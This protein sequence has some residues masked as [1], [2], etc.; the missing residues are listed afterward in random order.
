[1][2]TKPL[3]NRWQQA[4][5]ERCLTEKPVLFLVG[6]RQC[7]KTSLV[8]GLQGPNS[9][10]VYVSM[11]SSATLAAARSDPLGFVDSQPQRLFIIDE[12]SRAPELFPAIKQVVDSREGGSGQFLLISSVD[13][14]A[15]AKTQEL[16]AGYA[17][18]VRVRAP[19]QGE[20]AGAEPSFLQ[21]AFAGAFS[22]VIPAISRAQAV[23]IAL[24]GNYSEVQALDGSQRQAWYQNHIDL[25]L[26]QNLA[27]IARLNK[28]DEMH[29]LI[30]VAAAKSAQPMNVS[31]IGASLNI[32]RP[33]LEN[34]L[35]ML[36]ALYLIE[37][38]PPWTKTDY[39][40]VG[41]QEKLFVTDSG[42]IAGLLG[43]QEEQVQY[44][45]E[46]LNQL[47]Q[48][49]VYGELI[50]Q[51]G[52]ENNCQLF[53]YRDRLHR[54]IDFLIEQ[55]ERI[56][57]IDVKISATVNSTDFKHLRWF[58]ENLAGQKP[59][60]SIVLYPG[61]KTVSLGECQWAVP[62]SLLWS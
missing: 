24:V 60:I 3:V 47:L 26:E 17:V 42:L 18:K 35:T 34:Y 49:L 6:A 57:G 14:A 33:T 20:L 52:L 38:V 40:R 10:T 53:H 39:Q 21:S 32:K 48:T 45:A 55:N 28:R 7:G 5:I 4:D 50:T 36:E 54:K 37:R 8:K 9:N 15:I 23:H 16:L 41:K 56:I 11:E 22:N 1:M 19:S 30:Q 44:D 12:V 61:Q 27:D 62:L 46:K 59:F 2:Q 51:C 13:L 58:Q 29:K 31:E 25:V 43:W